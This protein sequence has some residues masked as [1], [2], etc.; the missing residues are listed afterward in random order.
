MED[1][2]GANDLAGKYGSIIRLLPDVLLHP[3]GLM[4]SEHNTAHT[5]DRTAA[6]TMDPRRLRT[7]IGKLLHSVSY[8]D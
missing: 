8:G 2:V 6:I 3:V 4:T 5:L 1:S 7:S